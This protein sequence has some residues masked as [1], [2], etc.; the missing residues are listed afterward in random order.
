VAGTTRTDD[1]GDAMGDV[2]ERNTSTS[3]KLPHSVDPIV[4]IVAQAGL[5]TTAG[6]DIQIAAGDT[7]HV[8]SGHDTNQ[9][10]GG[11]FR[12]HTGQAIGMLG[13]ATKPGGDAAGTGITF[14]AGKGDIDYQAQAS[15]ITIAA[16]QDVKIQS[17]TAHID[18]A[19]AKKI[20]LSTAGGA[21][22]TIEGG[23]ITFECPGK[24]WVKAGKKSFVSGQIAR[25]SLPKFAPATGPL[26]ETF[27]FK[28]E[29]GTALVN[30]PFVLDK[31]TY[32]AERDSDQQGTTSRVYSS[33]PEPVKSA[34]RLKKIKTGKDSF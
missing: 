5:A 34:L 18:W 19:A 22:V 2:A 11:A 15:T 27:S 23:N 29:L 10:V 33:E 7:L 24:I 26:D 9:A 32:R 25:A 12:L 1:F 30:L 13:G 14:I 17:Q 21:S 16:K 20:V 6:Q 28:D 4:A 8:A 3:K 31:G